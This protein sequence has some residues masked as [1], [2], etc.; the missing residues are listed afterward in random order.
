MRNSS[1]ILCGFMGC[2]KSTVGKLAADLMGFRFIDAD[3][4]I[5]QLSGKTIPEIFAQEGESAFREL[6]H[7]AMKEL[8]AQ[9]G[10]VVASGGGALTFQRNVEAIRQNRAVIVYLQCDF[11][12]CY[13]RIAG[14]K[15]RPLV[16]QNNQEQLQALYTARDVLYRGCAQQMI[17]NNSSPKQAAKALAELFTN[18]G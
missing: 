1:I 8:S 7:Q 15:N 10:M 4:Y 13:S 18:G 5:Q 11:P 3:I 2:G 16:Q 6:E 9:S 12:L 17:S 14:D